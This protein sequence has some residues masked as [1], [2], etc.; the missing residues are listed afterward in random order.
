M[1]RRIDGYWWV[2]GEGEEWPSWYY[3]EQTARDA[4]ARKARGSPGRKVYI[5]D[6]Q[7]VAKKIL[8]D[9]LVDA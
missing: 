5:G 8:P 4:A 7:V 2:W 1:D 3:G 9:K 6:L